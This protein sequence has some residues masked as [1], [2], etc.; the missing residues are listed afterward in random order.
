M[1]FYYL[2]IISIGN[3]CEHYECVKES[4][5]KSASCFPKGAIIKLLNEVESNLKEI[6]IEDLQI[7]D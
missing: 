2:F 4:Y 6:L 7:G 5:T 3:Y 1:V